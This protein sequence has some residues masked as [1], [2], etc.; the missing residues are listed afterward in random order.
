MIHYMIASI[1]YE[2][3]QANI[4]PYIEKIKTD[5]VLHF[6]VNKELSIFRKYNLM[7]ETLTS[8]N[9]LTDD[10]IVVFIHDDVQIRDEYFEDKLKIYFKYKPN[11]G[12]AGVI[13]TTIFNE[14][15]GWWLTQ[16]MIKTRGRIIQGMD[17]GSEHV[18]AES[19]GM[20]DAGVV[21]ID[22]CIMFMQGK[23]AKNYKFDEH[24]YDG[25]HFYDVDT[26]FTLLQ[27]GYDIGI[28][29][30]LVKH[31]S[32]GPL[33]ENWQKSKEVF[34]TKWKKHIT[35]PVSIQSFR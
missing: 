10:D 5:S 28:I 34:L 13:G 18:M 22:G 11:V 1:D 32:E 2:K 27:Q 26:C 15:G 21:S 12:V 16:R 14:A 7:L 9:K 24:T 35:F 30:V 17:D 29:D 31:C 19:G 3:I 6:D 8:N 23:V 20:N 33:S 4:N 25:F